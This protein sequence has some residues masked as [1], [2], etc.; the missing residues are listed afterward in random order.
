LS[1]LTVRGRTIPVPPLLLVRPASVD[2]L[3][4]ASVALVLV[5]QSLAY[6]QLAGLPAERG[7]Y[8]AVVAPLAA[9][10]F[11]SSPYLQTGPV[12]LTSLLVLGA[13]SGLAPTGT[14]EYATLAVVLA[15]V[16]G[17]VR[18]LLG[19][20]HAGVVAYLI[21]RPM[22]L[23][24]I[25]GAAIVIVASQIPAAVGA[26]PDEDGLLRSAW[27]TLTH[28]GSWQT[29]AAVLAAVVIVVMLG[30]R[31]V[32]RLFPSVL[33]AVA[34]GLGYSAVI[35]YDGATI[36]EVPVG[37]PPL[38]IDIAWRDLALLVL[39]GIVIGLVGFAEPA[40]IARS[41]ATADRA[42]WDPERE[43]V[44]QGAANVAAA[45]A[46][47]FPVG[48]S[49]SRSALNRATGARTAWSGAATGLAV[50]AFLPVA[51]VLEPLPT[52]VLAA[53]VV[54]AVVGQVRLLPML[55]LARLSRPQFAVAATTFALTLALVPRIDQAI[56]VGG[57]LAVAVHLRRELSLEIPARVDGETLHLRPR[58]VL[59]FG[60]AGRLEDTFGGLLAQHA[61]ARRLVVHLDGLGRIDTTGALALRELLQDARESGLD[62]EVV[63]V[64]PRW[65]G[66]VEDVID[67]RT[68]PLGRH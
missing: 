21:S 53:I 46:G 16:V 10:L 2:V 60:S 65:R 35:G 48:G 68:D 12:A 49:L 62:V 51:F 8:A 1:T 52:A 41:F 5:P 17:A 66:L 32:H 26:E 30:G 50:L 20:L 40:S 39:P 54:G 55:R 23:G 44:G 58:G 9:A 59:W 47:G 56:V 45:V 29:D 25:P 28:P 43:L 61:H 7:L 38:G 13:L 4:G 36:G 34:L 57:A 33:A 11:A 63:D 19:L 14:D 27:W 67:R 15:L 42:R 24:F 64:R 31:L 3:A 6:A 37:L 18:L 22:L